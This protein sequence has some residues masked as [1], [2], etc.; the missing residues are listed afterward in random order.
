M[1][2]G[3]EYGFIR[4]PAVAEIREYAA[5]H[6]IGLTEEQ[7]AELRPVFEQMMTTFDALEEIPEP[8]PDTP[9][10]VRDA[11]EPPREGEDPHNAFI[12]F[13][14]V[15]GE[16]EGPLAGLRAGVK[17]CIAVA[18]VPMTNG[19]RMM[20]PIVPTEDAVAVE[21]I[22]AAGAHVVGKTN[23][24]AQA[25]GGGEGSAFGPALY[26]HNHR[27]GTGGSSTGSA[28][29]VA[30][31]MV[32]F[33]LGTDTAGSV[34][35]PSAHC[36]LVGMKATHGLVPIYGIAYMDHTF[37]HIGPLTTDVA[38]NARVLEAL[39]GP[40]ERDPGWHP[41]LPEPT[42]YTHRLEDGVAG[43]EFA[44]VEEALAQSAP[45]VVEAVEGAV[46][47]LREA[48]ARVERVSVPLWSVAR[49]ISSGVMTFSS[50]AMHESGGGGYF[51]AGRIDPAVLTA[52]MAQYRLTAAD[53]AV[54]NQLGLIVAEHLRDH[55]LGVHYAKAQNLRVELRAQ[56]SQAL[57][58]GRVLLTPTTPRT[59]DP[60]DPG[61]HTFV[62]IL[63][64][65]LGDT[66]LN[67]SPLNITGH[68]ALTVPVG[69]AG[70]DD[71]PVGLQLIGD[72][73]TEAELYRAGAVAIVT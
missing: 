35:I 67:T 14:R 3:R 43:M 30:A 66:T 42:S 29:A 34:R 4:P 51:H 45:E 56:I 61:R 41:A 13:C 23:M 63:G 39:A 25:K 12:R 19:T 49:V 72:Y 46:D 2:P 64:R 52:T 27:Y 5:R 50:R 20:P 33:A 58:G 65:V 17:D 68:P 57:A 28:A 18:G 15:D 73:Y 55:Y 26:P 48:G 71:L 70:Q 40:D 53:L 7:A 6:R 36:G 32:D 9:A 11:G 54:G 1:R 24:E 21:R 59:A 10:R 37:D 16:F 62:E 60:V 69:V 47:R 31:G 38:L 22:L 44:L 8:V